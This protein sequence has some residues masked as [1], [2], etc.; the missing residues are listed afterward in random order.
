[1]EGTFL[2]LEDLGLRPGVLSFWRVHSVR[3]TP[4]LVLGLVFLSPALCPPAWAFLS[5][6]LLLHLKDKGGELGDDQ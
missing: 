5:W 3:G 1:M 6:P 4:D 2:E